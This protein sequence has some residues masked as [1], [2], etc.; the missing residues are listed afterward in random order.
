MFEIDGIARRLPDFEAD[1]QLIN[2]VTVHSRNGWGVVVCRAG[3]PTLYANGEV[4]GRLLKCLA[5]KK[6]Y[7]FILE[8]IAQCIGAWYFQAVLGKEYWSFVDNV[9]ARFSLVKGYSRDADANAI[10]SLFWHAAAEV[11]AAPFFEHVPSSAQLADKVSRN[12]HADA[13]HQGWTRVDLDLD[14][15]WDLLAEVITSGGVA[16]REHVAKLA[17]IVHHN[18]LKWWS[19]ACKGRG[20]DGSGFRTR[21]PDVY[22]GR[23]CVGAPS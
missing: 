16:Q 5:S 14:D 3:R 10:V 17:D 13:L 23:G 15:L 19:A 22:S 8:V 11:L 1:G 21:R 18:E 6:T 4:P 2:A 7:I 20:A 12:E 9:G